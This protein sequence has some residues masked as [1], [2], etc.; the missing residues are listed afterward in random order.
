[1]KYLLLPAC[2]LVSIVLLLS[3][4]RQ[5]SGSV[6]PE[7]VAE[8]LQSP[9]MAVTDSLPG[10]MLENRSISALTSGEIAE[11]RTLLL[12]EQVRDVPE[13][14]YRDTAEGDRGD[15]SDTTFYIYASNAQCLGGRVVKGKVLMDDFSLSDEQQ[16]RLTSLLMPHLRKIGI[17]K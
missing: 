4:C 11:L 16:L 2:S 10:W 13:K 12:P 7:N 15:A 6:I 3:A 17:V 14:Y 5:T 9:R 8:M 1:M